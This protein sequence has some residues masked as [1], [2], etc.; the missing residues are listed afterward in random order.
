MIRHLTLHLT[1]ACNLKCE[2]CHVSAIRNAS[3]T[4]GFI[5]DCDLMKLFSESVYSVSVAG[6]EPFLDKQRLYHLLDMIPSAVQ[7]VAVTTNGTLLD[8]KDFVFLKSRNVRLR[9]SIDGKKGN[10]EANRGEHTYEIVKGNIDKAIYYGLRVDLL[11]TVSNSNIDYI[12]PF[13]KEI[14]KDGINNITLLHFTPKGRGKAHNFEEVEDVEWF[15][16]VTTIGEK[17][18]N[19]YTRVW[20]QPRFLTKELVKY[21]NST[22]EITFCNCFNPKYAYVDLTTGDVYPCGLSFGT[23]LLFGNISNPFIRTINDVVK[24]NKQFLI[25]EECFDCQYLSSCKGGAKCYS[26]LETNDYNKKDPH[27]TG[28]SLLPICPFPAILVSGP[29]MQ[30]KQPTVV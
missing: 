23:P 14:D 8:D 22:R 21:C 26:W 24:S 12:I 20:I 18:S 15:G 28:N 10:H 27:C 25:P 11:T 5:N 1:N 4:N 6:G 2:Y 7:S 16:L 9:F 17:L 13:V 30:T 19:N 3:N 29:P